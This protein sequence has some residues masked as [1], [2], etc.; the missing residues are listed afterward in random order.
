MKVLNVI[1]KIAVWTV[2]AFAA[3]MVIFTI[4][5]VKTL[6]R[7]ERSLFGYKFFIVQSDSMSKTDFS[8]GDIIISKSLT[9]EGK[10]SLKEGDIVTFISQ[11]SASFG[12]TVTHKI[13]EVIKTESGIQYRTYGTTTDSNDESL[14]SPAYVLG[15]YKARIPHL[16]RFFAFLKTTPGYIIFIL[17]PFLCLIIFQSI[18][19]YQNFK[20]YRK[21]QVS[22]LQQE[23]AALEE[24]RKKSEEMMAKLAELES[25]LNGN[26][27]QDET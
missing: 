1:K 15:Q 24:E 5:S 26:K 12:E 11:N 7:N 6:D 19:V 3:A 2:V 23:R 20:I 4:V 10:K 9:S 18:R 14:V 22:E 8:A 25:K 16:G 27:S 13:R 21:E 17:I